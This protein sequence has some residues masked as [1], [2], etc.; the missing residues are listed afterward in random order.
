M[1]DHEAAGGP[2]H[3]GGER[4]EQTHTPS[5]LEK[6]GAYRRVTRHDDCSSMSWGSPC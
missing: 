1:H 3:Q 5:Q 2:S 6:D 4:H